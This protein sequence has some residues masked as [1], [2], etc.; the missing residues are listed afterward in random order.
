MGART[1][2]FRRIATA[3]AILAPHALVIAQADPH[4]EFADLSLEELLGIQVS[5]V[6]RR[7]ESLFDA[8]AAVYVITGDDALESGA[9]NL[10]SALRLA[11]GL[12]VGRTDSFNYA[13]ASRGFNDPLSSKLHVLVDG[14]SVYGQLFS[15]TYWN[16][17]D[18]SFTDLDRIEVIRG[19]GATLWGTNAVNGVINIISKDAY[20]TLGTHLL[21]AHGDQLDLAT[22]IRHG[23]MLNEATAARVYARVQEV[24]DFGVDRGNAA[25]GWTG[26]TAGTRIDWTRAD[27]ARLTMIGELK[28]VEVRSLTQ[29]PQLTPP[30]SINVMDDQ[31]R[32]GGNL[33][34]KWKQPVGSG[35]LTIQGSYEH[36]V[37][38]E[39]THD[40]TRDFFDFDVQFEFS[41]SDRHHLVTGLAYRRD[42]DRV[43][44][45]DY[46]SFR[47]PDEISEFFSVFIQD[48]TSLFAENLMLTV[49]SKFEHTPHGGWEIQ[50]NIRASWEISPNNMVWASIARAVRV[51]SRFE[52]SIVGYGN[53]VPPTPVSPLPLQI[54]SE[55]NPFIKPEELIAYEFGHRIR[56]SDQLALDTAWFLNRYDDLR[57][58]NALSFFPAF[59]P[60]PHLVQVI[61]PQNNLAG[62]SYGFEAL[63]QWTPAKNFSLEASASAI[64]F[65]L[66]NRDPLAA[67]DSF[68]SQIVQTL[69]DNSPSEQFKLRASWDIN[70]AWSID[71]LLSHSAAM[72]IIG[73][74]T[75]RGLDVRLGWV[76][77]P[78]LQIELIG[79]D[80]LDARHPEITE[81]FQGGIFHEIKR[82]AY[83]RCRWEF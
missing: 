9:A 42:D 59:D 12:Q 51:P 27:G 57:A 4:L 46:L 73:I 61:Q 52:R 16:Y 44:G 38:R 21:T 53:V 15:G 43:V 77:K 74:P 83:L 3:I 45:T 19:P 41:A 5:S 2:A 58:I 30:Y 65:E 62:D 64:R 17:H 29:V 76:V 23:W 39:Y 71:A 31:E 81:S 63:L 66:I 36:F 18:I 35:E 78:G 82:S 13:V 11:P 14:R 6:S 22:E 26:A 34:M 79:Q 25:D 37:S 8:P 24:R 54:T 69:A 20:Q 48:E 70:H 28:S 75:Y 68:L 72:R 47:T 10:P 7:A 32:Y 33:L 50:P 40:E 67:G 1:H 49:G 80:L 55:G 60:V 56:F